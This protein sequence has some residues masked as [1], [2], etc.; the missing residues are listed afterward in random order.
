MPVGVMTV[1]SLS[2]NII[3]WKSVVSVQSEIWV[4]SFS[5]GISID[6]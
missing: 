4:I 5:I 2:L 6:Y 1:P 3:I